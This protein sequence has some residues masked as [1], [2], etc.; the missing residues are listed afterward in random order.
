VRDR[1]W[2]VIRRVVPRR[3]R[4]LALA[5][6]TGRSIA[7]LRDYVAILRL[8][9]HEQLDA[10]EKPVRVRLKPLGG[11]GVDL[12]P[13]TADAQVVLTTFYGQY[14]VPPGDIEPQVIWD[15]GSNLGL[16]V[17]HFALLF[18]DARITGVEAQPELAELARSNIAT[19]SDRCSIV[20]GAVWSVD[21]EIDF[22]G[23]HGHEDGARVA[24]SSEQSDFRHRVRAYALSTLLAAEE[25]VDFLKVDIEGGEQILF[26]ENTAWATRVRC[27]KVEIHEPYT[28]EECER[29]LQALGFMT[30]SAPTPFGACVVA[31]R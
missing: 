19:W 14:H 4:D 8:Q 2:S 12:R 30:E 28:L 25:T 16:T 22:V 10:E 20:E 7:P 17:A 21:G 23:D 29:D 1:A 3:L 26:T 9:R 13:G 24:T 6:T 18:P 31:R 5:L 11:L 27:L 15:L